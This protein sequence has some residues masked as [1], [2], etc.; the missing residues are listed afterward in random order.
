M[1]TADHLGHTLDQAINMERDGKRARARY[2]AKSLEVRNQL[3]FADPQIILKALHIFSSDTYGCM[4]WDL[5]SD[6]AESFFKCWNTN[7]KLVFD[8]PRSTFTY[9]V[10][11]FFASNFQSLRNQIYSR[12]AGF[13]RKL[14]MSPSK[15][16][17]LLARLVKS[18]PRSTTRKNLNM[19]SEKTSMAEPQLYSS[20]RLRV[21]LPAKT[22]PEA[23]NWR[24]GLMTNLLIVRDEKLKRTEDT[25]HI[26]AMTESLCST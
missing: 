11:G 6:A 21:A 3:N 26:C 15:E 7:V 5:S 13:Y 12:F 4:L 17:Q 8:V 19:L 25:R 1:E 9:L 16:V 24:L 18:D 2:I 20:E 23:E 14:L 10:E 22:V